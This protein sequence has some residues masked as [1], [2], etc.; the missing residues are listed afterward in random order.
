MDKKE[1]SAGTC[2]L[3]FYHVK[4]ERKTLKTLDFSMDFG[5][6]VEV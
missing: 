3:R 6:M 5:I 2:I 4:S 1:S